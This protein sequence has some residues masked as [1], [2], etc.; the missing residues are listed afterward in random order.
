MHRRKIIAGAI[1]TISVGFTL[2]S[3]FSSNQLPD[4]AA[5]IIGREPTGGTSPSLQFIANGA[6]PSARSGAVLGE[7]AT[8]DTKNLT[9]SLID[10]YLSV[11]KGKNPSGPTDGKLTIPSG[12]TIASLI[13]GGGENGVPFYR[14]TERDIRISSDSSPVAQKRYLEALDAAL[15]KRFSPV[16]KTIFDALNEMNE[17]G[18]MTTLGELASAISG[19]VSDV[20]ALPVP[21]ALSVAH[22]D[23]L[24][25]WQEKLAMYN[26]ISEL[27]SDPY[28]A[29]IALKRIPTLVE[30]GAKLQSTLTSVYE[31]L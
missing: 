17:R 7:I 21:A 6:Q 24:N 23:W 8:P 15:T 26:A 25:L 16:Q 19:Y 27:S 18:D 13:E 11:V 2:W 22:L 31:N 1:I 30:N 4:A 14:F 5:S 20:L 9:D 29:Y 12:D 3:L 10:S 28:A